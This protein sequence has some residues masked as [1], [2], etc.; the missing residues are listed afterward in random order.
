MRGEFTAVLK[1]FKFYDKQTLG[2][3]SLFNKTKEIFN[4]VTLELP[5]RNNERN[6]SSIPE[7]VYKCV[8][9]RSQKYGL[10]YHLLDVQ[11]RTLILIHNG[12][13]YTH[14]RGCV[15]I[16]RNHTDI[17]RDGYKDV[18]SSKATKKKL[19]SFGV[20]EFII[21]IINTEE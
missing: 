5:F 21:E 13:Y 6:I 2:K 11:G 18:T 1:R 16:G 12:N 7:G 9:R 8:L 17:N 4:C 19:M 20:K 14:T 10:H 3:L 15:L